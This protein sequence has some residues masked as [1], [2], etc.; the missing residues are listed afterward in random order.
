MGQILAL[1][2]RA[3]ILRLK[4]SEAYIRLAGTY[5]PLVMAK[6]EA[7][8][9]GCYLQSPTFSGA[10]KRLNGRLIKEELTHLNVLFKGRFDD[11][12]V[13]SVARLAAFYRQG[14]FGVR[15]HLNVLSIIAV[16]FR[17][18]LLPRGRI[19][20]FGQ[21]A[22]LF[23]VVTRLFSF[24]SVS[25]SAADAALA[26]STERSRSE[27][28]EE[29]IAIFSSAITEVI[30]SL[31]DASSMCTNSSTDLQSALEATTQRSKLTGLSVA[32]IQQ[33]MTDHLLAINT[34][35]DATRIIDQEASRGRQLAQEAQ[36]AIGRS[37][38]SL[39]DLGSVLD[40][41]G[42]LVRS[43]S[44]IATQTNL[45]ALNA[46]IEA[47]R[48]GE[49]GRGFSVVAQEV[50]TLASQTAQATV[51][52]RRW[53]VEIASQKQ[54]VISQAEDASRS[55]SEATL[56]TGLISEALIEQDAAAENLVKTFQQS[57]QGSDEIYH[58]VKAIDSAVTMI[59]EQSGKLLAASGFLSKSAAGLNGCVQTFLDRVRSA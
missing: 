34:L 5:L 59:S 33:S 46:T 20:V 12:Y 41:I 52:I 14:E 39:H 55:I 58:A 18:R 54:K 40:R 17:K 57:T 6:A 56:A 19:L 38:G 11:E 28:M 7:D 3:E 36:S 16:C 15:A 44:D 26:L 21:S 13:A 51:D 30:A 53:I 32:R 29:A 37:E 49:A 4:G 8:I 47:A 43:I 24:D 1:A 25:L 42:G 23:D 50:K 10:Y 9:A 31:G 22:D 35:T 27:R 45:L 2:A 48:A